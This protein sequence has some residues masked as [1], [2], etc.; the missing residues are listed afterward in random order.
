MKRFV[1]LGVCVSAA[2]VWGL[3]ENKKQPLSFSDNLVFPELCASLAKEEAFRNFKCEPLANLSWENLS[4]EEGKNHCEALQKEYPELLAMHERCRKND[5]IGNPRKFIYKKVGAFSPST[6]RFML[7]AGDLKRHFGSL[8]GLKVLE[9]GGGYG[10]Q[11]TVLSSLFSLQEYAI[12]DLPSSLELQ[13]KYLK[14]LSIPSVLLYSLNALPST[15]YDLIVS[16]LAFGEMD[17]TLQK[18]FIDKVFS[19]ANAAY[20]ILAPAH[21]KEIPYSATEHKRVKP[22]P[23]EKLVALFQKQG[24]LCEELAE[25]PL[26]GKGHYILKLTR[27]S[28]DAL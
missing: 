27:K 22:Y 19:H 2:L 4:Y 15:S 28:H 16:D 13:R 17:R 26:S 24:F 10:G 3:K 25:V 20:L 12:A 23:K 1:L 9:M 18:T 7:I 5:L 8:D 21:W 14:E 11:C 6:L